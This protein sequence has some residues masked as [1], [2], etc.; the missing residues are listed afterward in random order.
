M[1]M[2]QLV[3]EPRLRSLDKGVDRI[4][5]VTVSLASMDYRHEASTTKSTCCSWVS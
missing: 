1:R 3:S 5:F 4:L 2:L